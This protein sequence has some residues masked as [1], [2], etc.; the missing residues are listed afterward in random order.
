MQPNKLE[1]Q[2]LIAEDWSSWGN[3]SLQ[4]ATT[5]FQILG[6]A[7]VK[8]PVNLLATHPGHDV[9]APQLPLDHWLAT[10]LDYWSDVEFSGLALGYLGNQALIELWV[11]YLVQH[12]LPLVVIDPAMAD[13]GKLYGSLPADYVQWQRKL[14]PFADVLTPNLTEAELLLDQKVTT[15]TQLREALLALQ[16]Q[17]HGQDVVI[18]SVRMQDQI[19]CAYLDGECL[20]TIFYP[21]APSGHA[22]S[23]DLFT[24]IL[25]GSLHKGASFVDAVQQATQMTT[26]AVAQTPATELDLQLT[27]IIDDLQ[28]LRR[29]YEK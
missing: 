11:Q 15:K 25:A 29:S 6:I 19:G 14:L 13:H 23:G 24:S 21:A 28:E 2:F 27:P 12:Q 22:G 9:N 7:S 4:S 10:V 20:R 5:I 3:I 17:I 18:T 16:Q 1:N 26:K 8:L